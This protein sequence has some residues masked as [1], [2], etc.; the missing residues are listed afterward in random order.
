MKKSIVQSIFLFILLL[1]PVSVFAED[2]LGTFNFDPSKI[3]HPYDMVN[4]KG[5]VIKYENY[6]KN[7]LIRINETPSIEGSGKIDPVYLGDKLEIPNEFSNFLPPSY[8]LNDTDLDKN[9]NL[10]SPFGVIGDDGRRIVADT[11]QLPFSAI[12]Y[13]ELSWADGSEGFCTGTLIGRNRVLTNAHCVIDPETQRG[14]S[15]GMVYPG[16]SES[17]PWFGG[18]NIVDYYVASNWISTGLIAEDFA[19]LVLSATNNRHAGDVAGTLGIRQVTNLLDNNI[20]IYGYPSDLIQN[21]LQIDQ[22]GMRGR[23]TQEDTSTAFYEID[24]APGQSGSALLNANNQ[25]VGVH[26]SGYYNNSGTPILNGGPKMNSYMF[27]FVSNA[28]Q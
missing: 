19:V 9:N 23:V 26:S 17:T 20:G 8:I 28:L 1:I 4:S 6:S 18:Y 14:I 5:E 11:G 22:Y 24:T 25:I 27:T 2:S 15:S 3:S 7:S 13:I 10:I 21:T 12:S 16:V